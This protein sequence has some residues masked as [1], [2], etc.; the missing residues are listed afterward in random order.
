M[1][2]TDLRELSDAELTQKHEDVLKELTD[3]RLNQGRSDTEQPMLVRTRRR[4]LARI[5]TVMTEREAQKNG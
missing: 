4:E 1:K 5:K 2:A 3:L